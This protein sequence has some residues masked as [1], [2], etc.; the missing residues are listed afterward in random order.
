VNEPPLA[1]FGLDG[2]PVPLEGGRGTS[3]LVGNVVLK[4]A[5]DPH[6]EVWRAVLYERTPQA[7][8]RLPRPRRAVDGR[9]VVDGWVALER[10][11][12]EH[13]TS[14]QLDVLALSQRFHEAIAHE[15]R[16]SFL[17]R[18]SDPW[19]TTQR[20]V[21]GEAPLEPY[22]GMKHVAP[23]AAALRPVGGRPQLVHGD[24]TTNV[25]FA[26]PE[27][28]AIIDFSPWW[29][30]PE[31]PRAIVVADSLLWDNADP[32][33]AELIDPQFFLRAVLFRKIV[34]RLFRPDDG[35]RPDGDDHY[36]PVVELALS[37]A[38]IP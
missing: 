18:A 23:L 6:E 28:P 9:V 14:R 2:E 13:S 27:P 31:Y 3:L 7:G 22:L 15:P 32:V 29:A 30:P 25:L 4:P 5:G 10:L 26:D 8:F 37:R 19:T 35:E 1:A 36:A 38:E 20:A 34:D 33:F 12:G 16:P 17:D 21:W 11:D 24:L